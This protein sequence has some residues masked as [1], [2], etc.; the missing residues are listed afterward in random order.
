MSEKALPLPDAAG[1]WG[2]AEAGVKRSRQDSRRQQVLEAAA[3]LFAERGFAGTSMRDIAKA[4]GMLPGSLYYHFPSKSALLLAVYGEGITRIT[5]AVDQAL[6]EEHRPWDRLEAVCRAHLEMVLD[7]SPYA[8]VVIRVLPQDAADVAEAMTALRDSYE[9]RLRDLIADLDLS[10]DCDPRAFRLLLLGGLNW[11]QV[12]YRPG[13]TP[14]RDIA[15]QFLE[16]LKNGTAR[17][18]KG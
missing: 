2:A 9:R 11:A 3:R 14:P 15:A 6:A 4:V 12:W 13:G 7:E 10:T 1:D 17:R 16:C 8:R 18:E 5:L